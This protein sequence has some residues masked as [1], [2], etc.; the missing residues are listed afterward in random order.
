MYVC[1]RFALPNATCICMYTCTYKIG[2]IFPDTSVLGRTIYVSMEAT[3]QDQRQPDQ[4]ATSR[5]V[6][7]HLVLGFV[8][9]CAISM[10]LVAARHLPWT[11]IPVVRHLMTL[12]VNAIYLGIY[13][14]ERR[15]I[16]DDERRKNLVESVQGWCPVVENLFAPTVSHPQ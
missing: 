8:V 13:E 7:D 15:G 12:L 2:F 16:I 11:C 14:L 3:L 5:R 4:R 10:V 9:S 1:V 6:L